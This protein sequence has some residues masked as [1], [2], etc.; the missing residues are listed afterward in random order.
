[1]EAVPTKTE[2]L[3]NEYNSIS[4]VLKAVCGDILKLEQQIIAVKQQRLSLEYVLEALSNEIKT[5]YGDQKAPDP[6]QLGL[7]F[8]VD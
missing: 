5:D 7:D 8:S 1:M 6:D 2:L 4:E 3:T